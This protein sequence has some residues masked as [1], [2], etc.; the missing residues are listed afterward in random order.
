[1]VFKVLY[2]HN[3]M[4]DCASHHKERVQQVAKNKD[5]EVLVISCA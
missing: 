5:Q 2:D 1:V 3:H 4:L